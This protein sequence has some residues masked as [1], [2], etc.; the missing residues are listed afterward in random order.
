[1]LL[2][3][4][5]HKRPICSRGSFGLRCLAEDNRRH[6][7]VRASHTRTVPSD[8]AEARREAS[9]TGR[10][11]GDVVKEANVEAHV[12]AQMRGE[13]GLCPRNRSTCLPALRRW[14]LP[15]E[16]AYKHPSP[17]EHSTA[18]TY[19]AWPRSSLSTFPDLRPWTRMS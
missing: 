15:L 9:M 3:P 12:D 19:D 11:G 13:G 10:G 16:K 5:Q 7:L 1:M 17:G 2:A 8:E 4:L 14:R 6:S 18:F